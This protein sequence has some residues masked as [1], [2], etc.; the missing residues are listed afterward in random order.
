MTTEDA[1]L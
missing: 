1:D